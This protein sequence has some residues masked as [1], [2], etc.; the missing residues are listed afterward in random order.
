MQS[1]AQ[2][3]ALKAQRAAQAQQQ[4]QKAPAGAPAVSWACFQKNEIRFSYTPSNRQAG[5]SAPKSL[6]QQQQPPSQPAPI[7]STKGGL[8]EDFF[9]QP[10]KVVAARGSAHA[11]LYH[12][13]FFKETDCI[14]LQSGNS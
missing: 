9:E 6:Q 8:P 7:P 10:A 4:K 2:V 3:K 11:M 13:R 12:F 14:G 1:L 5:S